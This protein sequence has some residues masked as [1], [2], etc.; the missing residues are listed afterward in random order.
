MHFSPDE[1]HELQ[2]GDWESAGPI[3]LDPAL[4]LGELD[5]AVFFRRVRTFLRAIQTRG[6]VDVA[7]DG[8]LDPHFVADLL[9]PLG[10][11]RDAVDE[12]ME[13]SRVVSGRLAVDEHE[14]PPLRVIRGVSEAAG[15]LD[16]GATGLRLTSLAE[17]AVREAAAGRLF[18][19][20]F[21]T[22][23]RDFDPRALDERSAAPEP[24][25][26][27]IHA[28]YLMRRMAEVWAGSEDLAWNLVEVR[29]RHE[30][31]TKARWNEA[32]LRTE[33][34]LIEPLLGF[35]L[36]ER[37][38][39]PAGGGGCPVSRFRKTSLFDRFLQ[40]HLGDVPE[41]RPSRLRLLP[42]D[43]APP[44]VN[45]ITIELSS[46]DRARLR[47]Q[48][49]FLRDFPPALREQM[50]AEDAGP[51]SLLFGEAWLLQDLLDHSALAEETPDVVAYDQLAIVRRLRAELDR[52]RPRRTVPVSPVQRI[53]IALRR[54]EAELLRG[55]EV[56]PPGMAKAL[57]TDQSDSA[58][59]ISLT[60]S[61]VDRL[62]G[63]ILVHLDEERVGRLEGRL[64][65]VL[66]RFDD[67][68]E[69][70]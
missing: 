59:R 67:G 64:H 68:L 54:S 61:Q 27:R 24:L 47:H 3:R 29:G 51:V 40:F 1:L 66:R 44:E 17:D 30:P 12:A 8:C 31:L 69:H 15:L 2:H 19:R 56:L 49:D 43:P 25:P 65:E 45:G 7:A 28:L 16:R 14:M 9:Q 41:P 4:P 46:R 60:L 50:M 58:W 57:E 63:E 36:F 62:L 18:A 13:V 37:Q 11:A 42:R 26:H 20:L 34:E 5:G 21:R 23:F 38:R 6:G 35:G 52:E 55:L 48:P 22:A 10:W 53:P 70:S 32:L 39:L 33:M